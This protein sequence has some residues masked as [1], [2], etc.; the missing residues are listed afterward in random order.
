MQTFACMKSKSSAYLS[1]LPWPYR[2]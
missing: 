2:F 1:V